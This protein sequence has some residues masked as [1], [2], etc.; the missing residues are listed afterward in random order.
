MHIEKGLSPLALR[1]L[2]TFLLAAIALIALLLVPANVRS[3]HA[4]TITTS[5][6]LDV[7]QEDIDKVGKQTRL[8]QCLCYSYAY[9][10]TVTSGKVHDWSEYSMGGAPYAR[11]FPN[12][13][14]Y[15]TCSTEGATLKAMYEAVKAGK[16]AVVH[17]RMSNGGEH[18]VAVVG[19]E[20]A[21]PDNLKLG[22][23]LAIDS[24]DTIPA[25]PTAIDT[26]L[27]SLLL[28]TRNVRISKTSTNVRNINQAGVEALAR[29]ASGTASNTTSAAS[30]ATLVTA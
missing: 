10:Q 13:F 14:T 9:S 11:F 22:D 17:L 25:E 3:A 24:V 29:M 12:L 16:P 4:D 2:V 5:G 27:Y 19:Y 1:A 8:G 23:F 28:D 15:K 21:D 20:G 7:S 6:Y 26:D 18:W 30:G